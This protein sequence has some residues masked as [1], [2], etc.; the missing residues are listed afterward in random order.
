MGL[1][2]RTVVRGLM[3]KRIKRETIIHREAYEFYYGLG[4]I[5]SYAKVAEK[6]DTSVTSVN[7]WSQSFAWMSR[8]AEREQRIGNAISTKVENKE[9][10]NREDILTLLDQKIR[11]LVILNEATGEYEL[12]VPVVDFSDFNSLIKLF[13]LLRGDP[14]E[15]H[16]V[17]VE[18]I[19]VVVNYVVRIVTKYVKDPKLIAAISAD[20]T[21]MPAA[22]IE[23]Q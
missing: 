7:R 23:V 1:I 9:I 21:E 3:T 5:R 13:L 12:I 20:L 17:R 14:T 22:P 4:E 16:L 8:I 11:S 10:Q 19:Q 6:F 18:Y 2:E 15:S